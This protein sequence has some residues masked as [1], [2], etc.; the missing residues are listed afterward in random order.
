MTDCP[1]RMGQ[2]TTEIIAVTT[3]VCPVT[4]AEASATHT[5]I[6]ANFSPYYPVPSGS[7][8]PA[9]FPSGGF[10]TLQKGVAA[11]SGFGARKL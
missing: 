7:G 8:V 9:P 5:P 3:T 10:K 2:E 6:Q 4:A 11:P 1:A